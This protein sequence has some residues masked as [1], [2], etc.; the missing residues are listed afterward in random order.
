MTT[1]TTSE[2]GMTISS[3]DQRPDKTISGIWQLDPRR[4]NVEFRAAHFWGL[5]TVKGHFDG[6]HGRLDL[7][8]SPAIELTIDAASLQTG[9]G[10]RDRHLRSA[11]FFDID[12]HPQV[13]FL[14]ESVAPQGDTLKVHGSLSAAGRAIPIELDAQV[15]QLGS[16]LEIEAS[17][18]APHRELG[19]TYS[20]LGMIGAESQL[21]VRAHLTRAGQP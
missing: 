3:S 11:D 8:A 4:S 14:S 9:N 16:D 12:N 18:T 5:M 19:M 7:S 1:A 2:A 21:R 15:R 20:P 10:K 17:T 13:H 6:C